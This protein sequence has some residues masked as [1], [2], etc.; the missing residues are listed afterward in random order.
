[1]LFWAGWTAYLFVDKIALWTW[2]CF[3]A[4]GYWKKKPVVDLQPKKAETSK[5]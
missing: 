2:H 3:S 5:K 4:H 1:M